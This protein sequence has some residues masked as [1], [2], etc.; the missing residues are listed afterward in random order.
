[1]IIEPEQSKAARNLLKWKIEDLVSHAE[2]TP[3]QAR[4]FEQ[5][6]SR[7]LDVMEAIHQAYSDNGIR[8]TSTG[9]V[10]I[11]KDRLVLIEGDDCYLRLLQ[12]V[13]RTL[14]EAENKTMYIMYASDK[15]S[16]SAVNDQ[17][18]L[19]RQDGIT[20]YQIISDEDHYIMG[21]FE[22]YRTMPAKYFTNIVT[23]LYADKTAQVNGKESRITIQKDGPLAEREHKSFQYLWDNGDKPTKT[24]S[25]ERF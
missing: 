22:E 23:V 15:A 6:R 4:N 13:H 5:G 2:I 18:R 19:M 16:P 14:K 8:F 10:D 21:E 12:D 9:G 17:Y 7:A 25:E 11:E 24:I 3:D 1:M 20:M